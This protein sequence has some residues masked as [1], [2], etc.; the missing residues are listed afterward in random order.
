MTTATARVRSAAGRTLKS[1]VAAPAGRDS[2]DPPA[3]SRQRPGRSQALSERQ[4]TRAD[5][6]DFLP[7][8]VP[9]NPGF[10]GRRVCLRRGQGYL[11][12]R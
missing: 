8:Q 4:E 1:P 11:L 6:A 5:F 9:V 10:H 3:T 12:R 2:L 7:R